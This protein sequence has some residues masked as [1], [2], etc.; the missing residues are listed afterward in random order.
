MTGTA[1][2]GV[3][4]LRVP[5]QRLITNRFLS[6][7]P[8]RHV[9]VSFVCVPRKIDANG[10]LVLPIMT[11]RVNELRPKF[12]RTITIIRRPHRYH[13]VPRNLNPNA[14]NIVSRDN[15]VGSVT[16]RVITRLVFTRRPVF[17]L[18]TK[19]NRFTRRAI[20]KRLR[21]KDTTTRS[22]TNDVVILSRIR[23]D[24]INMIPNIATRP[25]SRSVFHGKKVCRRYQDRINSNNGNRR[26]RQVFETVHLNTTRRINNN[27]QNSVINFIARG[28]TKALMRQRLLTRRPRR[29]SSLVMTTLRALLQTIKIVIIRKNNVGHLR[30]RLFHMTRRVNGNGLIVGFVGHINVRRRIGK[31]NKCF[32]IFW[33]LLFYRGGPSRCVNCLACYVTLFI[34]VR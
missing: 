2:A 4:F 5:P 32:R 9:P 31:T 7:V 18:K 8:R 1:T 21:G 13:R 19:G 34:G 26:V 15:L 16:Y 25:R 6:G 12:R 30:P 23:L 3:I 10:L 33:G 22:G 29:L 11:K 20:T 27:K 24:N 17:R 28:T 14:N